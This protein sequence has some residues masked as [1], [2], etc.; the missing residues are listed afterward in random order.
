MLVLLGKYN[1]LL[2]AV[3]SGD[4]AVLAP[5]AAGSL[6]G[7]LSVVRLLSWLLTHYQHTTHAILSGFVLGSL[8][9]LWPWDLGEND[10]LVSTST[11]PPDLGHLS[12]A[13]LLMLIGFVMV[14]V[15]ERFAAKG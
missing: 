10:V 2:A 7:L 5:V 14:L 4:L 3:T 12:A 9:K 8:R 13:L 6:F 15:M 11:L 1:H